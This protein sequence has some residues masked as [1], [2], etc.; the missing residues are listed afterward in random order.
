[1]SKATI[2]TP[3]KVCPHILT[4]EP[5]EA[6]LGGT[7]CLFGYE[8]YYEPFNN[9]EESIDAT[10]GERVL[11]TVNDLVCSPRHYTLP[12][13]SCYAPRCGQCN[14]KTHFRLE[15]ECAACPE[16]PWLMPLILA[17][18]AVF[19]AIGMYILTKKNVN[20]AVMSIGIDYFQVLGLFTRSRVK[21]PPEIKWLFRQFQWAMFDIDLTAPECAFR[22]FMTYENKF[23][24]KLL[25]PLLGVTVIGLVL[26]FNYGLGP[27]LCPQQGPDSD[28]DDESERG[29]KKGSSVKVMPQLPKEESKEEATEL[30]E[31]KHFS[32]TLF[33]CTFLSHFSLAFFSRVF[34][35]RFSLALL[36]RAFVSPRRH[37][38]RCT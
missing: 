21:W 15:G 33:S 6:C 24:I 36:S 18:V 11:K 23:Y 38:A 10:T 37:Q 12:D 8:S 2:S 13:G 5:K 19:A 14:P 20:L 1:M 35:S 3:R 29:R 32:L 22:Q 4:C 30:K 27:I 28:S 34:L 17:G 7:E 31:G 26:G 9:I 25:L 16:Y